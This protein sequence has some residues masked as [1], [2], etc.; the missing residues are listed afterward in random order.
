LDDDEDDFNSSSR[1][2]NSLNVQNGE[3]QLKN[4]VEEY[5]RETSFL[6]T[7]LTIERKDFKTAIED[8][9]KRLA[10]AD[11][12][13]ERAIMARDQT[14]ELLVENKSH[15]IE[16]SETA[17][18]LQVKIVDLESENSQL[19]SEL[20][21]TKLMLTDLQIKYNMVEKQI[22]H[23]SE[24][25]TLNT[26]KDAHER[27]CA[28]IILMQ[29]QIESI[30][31]KYDTV[32]HENKNLEIRFNQL[33][34]SRESLIIDNSE[35]VHALN[36]SVE[37]AQDQIRN[38]Q[39]ITRSLESD[40]DQ[41]S[42]TID[43]YQELTDKQQTN[44][45]EKR[46]NSSIESEHLDDIS[47]STPLIESRILRINEELCKSRNEIKRKREQIK[48]YE[49]QIEE[50]DAELSKIRSDE[51]KAL[52]KLNH[53]RDEYIRMEG[54]TKVLEC[55]ISKLKSIHLQKHLNHP[56]KDIEIHKSIKIQMDK[57]EPED[58]KTELQ[59]KTDLLLAEKS[60]NQQNDSNLCTF[61]LKT[62]SKLIL[63]LF[64]RIKLEYTA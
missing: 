1:L 41:M 43:K 4:L 24:Q 52:V 33:Q 21:T 49:K 11:A 3:T 18:H 10:I 40:K 50:K 5:K 64:R 51:N 54:R 13:K 56:M 28:Q 31:T 7:Q 61:Y 38:L 59:K 47:N 34:Q 30:K 14:H 2:I 15:A 19:V 25:K 26:L 29:Q 20:E 62:F 32:V 45:M 12:E 42:K 9:E 37:K 6:Q 55:E 36:K 8:F 39:R 44:N 57:S 23:K 48:I 16:T 53:F 60:R 27:H 58:S 35:T 63:I 46:D 17:K 22:I